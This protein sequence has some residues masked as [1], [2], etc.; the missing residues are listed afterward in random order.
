MI[1]NNSLVYSKW[2]FCTVHSF[3]HSFILS[4]FHSTAQCLGN[5]VDMC[6]ENAEI[7]GVLLKYQEFASWWGDEHTVW[8]KSCGSSAA[9]DADERC[10]I[11][12]D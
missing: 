11:L 7:G 2:Y 1:Q 3:I 12:N 4:F 8:S 10:F 9:E 5:M 6:Q